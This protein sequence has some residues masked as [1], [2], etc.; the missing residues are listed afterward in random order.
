MQRRII[1]T[2]AILFAF[3]ASSLKAATL[4]MVEQDAC[5]YCEAWNRDVGVVYDK[6]P[7]GSRAVLRRIDIHQPLPE[8]L[9]FITG[10]IFTPTFVLVDKG[11]EIGR[12]RGYP[13]EDFFW[14][15][16]QQLIEKLPATGKHSALEQPVLVAVS[17]TQ[18]GQ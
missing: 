10:L 7:E 8:D 15:L 13:G 9:D 6:T 14:G 2:L 17:K 11:K 12:I 3:S 5:S 1:F 4:V 16:L 18:R